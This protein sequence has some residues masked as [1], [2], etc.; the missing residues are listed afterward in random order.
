M[1]YL[2]ADMNINKTSTMLFSIGLVAVFVVLIVLTKPNF[3][4]FNDDAALSSH[5]R[6]YKPL[7]ELYLNSFR[8][9]HLRV[10][11]D[12]RSQGGNSNRFSL[13]STNWHFD[14]TKDALFFLFIGP[15]GLLSGDDRSMYKHGSYKSSDAWSPDRTHLGLIG[16]NT[17][18]NNT[19][20]FYMIKKLPFDDN[21]SRDPAFK[22]AY[23]RIG[24]SQFQPYYLMAFNNRDLSVELNL[25][26]KEAGGLS[27]SNTNEFIYYSAKHGS[28]YAIDSAKGLF[29]VVNTIS[30]VFKSSAFDGLSNSNSKPIAELSESQLNTFTMEE[31]FGSFI[32][33]MKTQV[34]PNLGSKRYESLK[35]IKDN[36]DDDNDYLLGH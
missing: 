10:L 9:G 1:N 4:E 17:V 13:A 29:G 34:V 22:E 27:S 30:T 6:L 18:A 35:F 19:D 7:P 25:I 5:E 24:S 31:R 2:G 28:F 21:Y 32:K 8:S 26:I 12:S 20:N 3:L 15:S 33:V 36:L 16:L 14:E 23:A 11:V